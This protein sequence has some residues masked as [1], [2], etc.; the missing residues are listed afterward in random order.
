MR[1]RPVHDPE[2]GSATI[3]A[4]IIVPVLGLMIMLIV[5]GG[6]VAIAHQSVQTAAFQAARTASLARDPIQA[7]DDSVTSAQASL[8]DQDIRCT[9]TDVTVDTTGLTTPVGTPSSVSATVTCH[10]DVSDLGLPIPGSRTITA[11]MTSAVDQ[12]RERP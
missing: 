2:S 6:R 1:R 12:H 10:L 3:E 5:F 4:V 11:T 9:A 7:H 8:A